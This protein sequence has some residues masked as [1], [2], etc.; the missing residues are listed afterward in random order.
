MPRQIHILVHGPV[1]LVAYRR[2]GLGLHLPWAQAHGPLPANDSKGAATHR[3][4]PTAIGM[5]QLAHAS[6]GLWAQRAASLLTN[7]CVLAQCSAIWRGV[8]RCA[9]RQVYK[10]QCLYVFLTQRAELTSCKGF[11]WRSVNEHL[12]ETTSFPNSSRGQERS[13][14]K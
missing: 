5:G 7:I 11:Y 1:G 13:T 2:L 8:G 3:P 9:S 4:W 14:R 6:K 10:H 12:C